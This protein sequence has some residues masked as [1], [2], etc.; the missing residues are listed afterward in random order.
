MV[1]RWE[2]GLFLHLWPI[3]FRGFVFSLCMGYHSAHSGTRFSNLLDYGIHDSMN[4]QDTDSRP[5]RVRLSCCLIGLVDIKL[6][7]TVTSSLGTK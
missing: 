5:S 1:L 6:V 2:R 3:G 7:G 4:S